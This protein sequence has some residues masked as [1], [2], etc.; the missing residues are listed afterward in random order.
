MTLRVFPLTKLERAQKLSWKVG[1]ELN[2]VITLR[3]GLEQNERA[4]I[5]YLEEL[6]YLSFDERSGL[7]ITRQGVSDTNHDGPCSLF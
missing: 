5:D 2:S 7:F 1:G 3:T 6:L 4:V